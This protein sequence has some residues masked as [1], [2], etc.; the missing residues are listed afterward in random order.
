[1][2]LKWVKKWNKD[3][4]KSFV[5][6]GDNIAPRLFG[7]QA[8]YDFTQAQYLTL[9]TTAITQALDRS[10]NGNNTSI[11]GTGTARPTFTT[12]QLNGL[13]LAIFDG[14]D[15]L[16]LPAALYPIPQAANTVFIVAKRNTE[17][18]TNESILSFQTGAAGNRYLDFFNS[19]SGIIS[20]KNDNGAGTAINNGGN[21]NTNYNII[22]SSFNGTTG[23]SLSINNG[24]ATTGAGGL[25]A[26]GIDR[27]F[28]GAAPGLTNSLIGGIA[29][30]LIYNRALTAAEITQVNMYLANKYGIWMSGANW[31][32]SYTPW[33][34]MLIN[35]WQINK[36]NAFTNTTANPFAAIYDPTA[37]AL[38]STTSLADTGR[39]VNTATEATNPPV[40]TAAAIGTDNGLLYNG[41]TTTLNA[42][43]D[44]TIDNIFDAG[45]TFF[46]VIKPTTTGE[47]GGGRIFDKA[48]T[49]LLIQNASGGSCKM[50]FFKSFSV[51]SGDWILTNTDVT[52]GAAN[53]IAMTY[54][55]SSVLNNPAIYVNS[56]TA[57]AVTTTIPPVGTVAN[58]A[59]QTLYLGN[60]SASSATFDGYLGK[61]VFLKSSVA[62]LAQR[63]AVM[64]FLATEYGVT[65]T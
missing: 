22:R 12:N 40:N 61:Y 10:G 16:A 57:K 47:G 33:Q 51:T 7:L 37:A 15:S 28:I 52:L 63:T 18:G 35:A 55:A 46:G 19:T 11:Q 25:A 17:A 45:G 64:N 42:G 44:T 49:N 29:E 48:N 21:T 60:N 31:I 5:S 58:D 34:Q 23:L 13:P 41:T 6:R 54:D 38:G 8:W 1:M 65:L 24:V 2:S 9:A 53:I 50:R 59:V 26:T 27:G 36:D 43:S 4:T 14:G 62:T 30:I 39:G 20:Y 3:W 56:L 32:N